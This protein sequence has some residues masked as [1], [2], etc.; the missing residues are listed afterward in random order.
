MEQFDRVISIIS[1][2]YIGFKYYLLSYTSAKKQNEL[3][4]FTITHII[5][6]YI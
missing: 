3:Y 2:V 1:V 5:K 4:V 6:I